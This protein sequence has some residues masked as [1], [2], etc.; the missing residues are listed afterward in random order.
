MT[1]S[2][3]PPTQKLVNQHGDIAEPWYRFISGLALAVTNFFRVNDGDGFID[4]DPEGGELLIF[5]P[6]TDGENFYAITNSQV[7]TGGFLQGL[8]M[9]SAEGADTDIDLFM[10][11]KGDRGLII[12]TPGGSTNNDDLDGLNIVTRTTNPAH[13]AAGFGTSIVFD[14]END[15]GGDPLAGN[16]TCRWTSAVAGAESAEYRFLC[17]IN[18]AHV[19]ELLIGDG[20]IVGD[21]DGGYQGVGTISLQKTIYTGDTTYLHRTS[22]TMNNGAGASVGTLNNAPAAGNPTKWIAIDD[23]GTTRYIPTW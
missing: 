18:G 7:Q 12:L 15:A 21:P 16:I 19:D 10:R 1:A 23:N 20:L 8:P 13:G 2:P 4:A 22:E 11:A 14:I 17:T 9:I 3:P 5:H 6:V